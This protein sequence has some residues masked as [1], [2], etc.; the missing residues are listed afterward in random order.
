[1]PKETPRRVN[2]GPGSRAPTFTPPTTPVATPSFAQRD[3]QPTSF[4]QFRDALIAAGQGAATIANAKSAINSRMRALKIQ[5]VAE[6]ER[7]I[8]RENRAMQLQRQS[9]AEQDRP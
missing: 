9:E 6:T 8:E 2:Q 3:D 7:L 1:M 4:S 5:G